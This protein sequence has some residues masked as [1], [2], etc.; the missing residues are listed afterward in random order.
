MNDL[1]AQWTE[2]LA[3]GEEGAA[4]TLDALLEE[5]VRRRASDIHIEPWQDCV[6][7][8]FRVDGMLHDVARL[9][10][11]H[12]ARLTG[13]LKVVA[14]MLTYQRDLPQDGRIDAAAV[15]CGKAMRVSTVPTVYG[16]KSVVRILDV[17]P[18][19]FSLDALGF[20]PE[21]A[22]SLRQLVRRPHGVL[23]LTGPASSGKTTTIYALLNEILT[24]RRR[25]TH[26]VT[27]EDPVEYRLGQ[28]TQC[29]VNPHVGFTFEAALRALLR[30]DPEVIML[31]EIRDPE[32]ARIAVQA[33]LTGHFVISTVHSGS[34]AGV[35][36]RLLDMGVEPFLAA[37]AV[38]GVLAQRLVRRICP[39]CR[40][41]DPAPDPV[42]KACFGIAED[43]RPVYHGAGCDACRQVG[44]LGRLAVG[45]LL[46]VNEAIA[47]LV[48]ARA[49]T[50]VLHQAALDG[51]MTPM[52]SEGLQRVWEGVTTLEELLWVLPAQDREA[53]DGGA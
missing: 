32:T 11:A 27:L 8:R 53:V 35:F 49:R 22:G 31:G 19:M 6:A 1:T 41:E 52:L 17:D 18:R 33:G 29:E 37:S 51:G 14:Q 26:M 24:A 3:Q 46:T 36:T 43:P 39:E 9:P 45:E 4:R 47:E 28:V 16:E 42:A 20:L 30:Q 23:L 13:R 44:Y 34:A 21:L 15:S 48:L 10:A 12:H 7:V 38:I 50:A 25:A 40:Q 2:L 5:A